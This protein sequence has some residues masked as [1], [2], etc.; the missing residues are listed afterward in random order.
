MTKRKLNKYLLSIVIGFSFL[1][2]FLPLLSPKY[3]SFSSA[4]FG[5]CANIGAGMD[6]KSSVKTD[7]LAPD[8]TNRKWTVQE[9]FS[10]SMRFTS[11]NGEGEGSWFL[12]DVG[13][14]RGKNTPGWEDENVQ[15]KVT[16]IRS[17]NRCVGG[18]MTT[19]PANFILFLSS[20]SVKVATDFVTRMF[21]SGIIC[22]SS[23]PSKGDR[24]INILGTVGGQNDAQ[25]GIIGSLRDSV[26]TPLATLAFLTT[27]GWLIYTGLIKRQF[28]QSF[29]GMLWSVGVFIIGLWFMFQPGL[30]ASAPQQVNSVIS[31]CIVGA[32]NGQS[33]I[34]GT[35]QAPSSLVGEECRSTGDTSGKDGAAMAA[36][37]MTCS[38]WKTFVLDAW[39]RAQFGRGYDSMYLSDAPSGQELLEVAPDDISRY[40][41]SLTS[42]GSA[43]SF[44]HKRIDTSGGDKIYNLALYQL[45]ISTMM[46]SEGDPQFNMSQND[47]RWYNI[48]VPVAKDSSMWQAWTPA[49]GRSFQR[50][51]IV[52][53]SLIVSIAVSVSLIILSFWGMIYMF[54]GAI[55]MAFAPLFFLLAIHPGKGRRLFLG[56]LESVVSSILKYMASSLFVIVALSLYA[57]ILS[58]TDSYTTAFIGIMIMVGTMTMY[59]KEIVNLLG[60]SNLGGQR[61]SNAVGDMIS[62]KA[63]R[64]K[65]VGMS[66]A[67]S[68]AGGVYAARH[69]EG[70]AVDK[71]K[72]AA[73]MGK[74]GAVDG[75]LRQARRGQGFVS[76]VAREADSKNINRLED[77]LNKKARYKAEEKAKNK[78]EDNKE[79]QD[80]IV[81]EP[82]KPKDPNG[83]GDNHEK[84]EIKETTGY[85]TQ[86]SEDKD[87][88]P[89]LD[90]PKLKDPEIP[91]DGKGKPQAKN[92]KPNA[93]PL[94]PG[95]EKLAEDLVNDNL[96]IDTKENLDK[97]NTPIDKKFNVN[98]DKQ[99]T[100]ENNPENPLS[101]EGPQNIDLDVKDNSS[102]GMPQDLKNIPNNKAEVD[103]KVDHQSTGEM[104]TNMPRNTI[105][106]E[107]TLDIENPEPINTPQVKKEGLTL[108]SL[109]GPE[110]PSLVKPSE[111]PK[112][113]SSPELNKELKSPKS[114]NKVNVESTK[115][116]F[117]QK[118]ELPDSFSPQPS[119]STQKQQVDLTREVKV[120]TK[121]DDLSSLLK[122][123]EPLSKEIP[124]VNSNETSPVKESTV[125]VNKEIPQKENEFKFKV[126]PDSG[127]KSN[128]PPLDPN[129][130]NVNK[131]K[132]PV[133]E[134]QKIEKVKV[135]K[136]QIKNSILD[137]MN[138]KK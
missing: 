49:A 83:G 119:V 44:N 33:C 107:G 62:D 29:S 74:Q 90:D 92:K 117:K 17:W 87:K 36:N 40:G 45:Y 35:V 102:D 124:K 31:T 91:K 136:P 57:S 132:S 23:T 9:L 11:Y 27:A 79:N 131:I 100:N 7:I 70:N 134:S 75:A 64:S 25:G 89:K 34:D 15:K 112:I 115:V 51:T 76:G 28:R 126:K 59:R 128:L 16:G 38:I 95:G 135:P 39:S 22:T 103:F 114:T 65:E 67:G 78:G 137:D 61:M 138:N 58:S 42:S 120:N 111:E 69:L 2:A 21:D 19:G 77:E 63:K 106:K 18:P 109:D 110:N 97:I 4:S 133:I 32:M 1:V 80:P 73:A 53:A 98:A 113:Q 105:H 101:N 93:I 71:M 8:A 130:F 94:V 26:F 48:V 118:Q 13:T 20:V 12:A 10:N 129:G 66:I 104:P 82:T 116:E 56:W 6:S 47:P 3:P 68:T 72:G 50:G 99:K 125:S 24:C 81:E 85:D 122:Q 123:N 37:G 54:A 96:N 41:V 84:P 5:N 60:A 121:S 52:I 127:S 46:K 14:D 88:E 55:L 43:E 30:L 108:P 86:T